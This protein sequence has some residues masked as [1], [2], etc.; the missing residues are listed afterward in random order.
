MRFER[1]SVSATFGQYTCLINILFTLNRM[2]VTL[3]ASHN[4]RRY[5]YSECVNVTS[6]TRALNL[7]LLRIYINNLIEKKSVFD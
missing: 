7:G 3:A 1:E 4:L 6:D 5:T 2:Y